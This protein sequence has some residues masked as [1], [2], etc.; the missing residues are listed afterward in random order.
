MNT[1]IYTFDLFANQNLN[2]IDTDGLSQE[3]MDAQLENMYVITR[4][5]NFLVAENNN[6]IAYH[7]KQQKLGIEGYYIQTSLTLDAS[8]RDI[9][10]AVR[11]F[12]RGYRHR[13]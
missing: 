6:I 2:I 11:H 12:F 4:N 7:A 13:N 10:V 8:S 3:E 1:A 5:G 9:M